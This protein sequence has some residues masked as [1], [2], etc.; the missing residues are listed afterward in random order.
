MVEIGRGAIALR[1]A[2]VTRFPNY[3]QSH[4]DKG[5]REHKSSGKGKCQSP[6]KNLA[7]I[8]RTLSKAARA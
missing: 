2:R 6:A 3:G 5:P 1:Q 8:S 7:S 4:I